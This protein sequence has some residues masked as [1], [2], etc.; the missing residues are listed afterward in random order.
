MENQAEDFDS[1]DD[2]L[3]R[4]QLDE[5]VKPE[6]EEELLRKYGWDD[7][8]GKPIDD[9]FF[10]EA[11]GQTGETEEA[12]SFT[13]DIE[14]D[15]KFRGYDRGQVDHYLDAITEDYNAIC[16]KCDALEQENEGLRRALAN[17]NLPHE[18]GATEE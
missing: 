5:I 3:K 14:F 11:A 1:I 8:V 10:D 13:N 12:D 4:F 16:A 2:L 18:E 6:D 17:L 9:S 15:I 7:P